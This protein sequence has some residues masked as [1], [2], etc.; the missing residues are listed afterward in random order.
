MGFAVK[1]GWAAAVLLAGP[2]AAP[3]VLDSRRI[4]LS[5]PAIPES[6]QPYH[7]GTGTAREEGPALSRLLETV[8][9]FGGHSVA[10]LIR[11]HHDAQH[12]IVGG[13]VVV[14][15]LIDPATIAN[16]HIRIHAR[17][18][19]LFRRVVEDALAAAGIR[20]VVWRERDLYGIATA[21]LRKWEK[22][23]RA[24]V[25]TL[26]NAVEGAWRSEQKGATV[27]AWVVLSAAA[28]PSS[29]AR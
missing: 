28:I 13:G 24:A 14:G 23:V 20:C 7:A 8:R 25:K 10:E 26:G 3:R 5:D 27:A 19:Q 4:E 1:S 16:A 11:Q 6:R 18:G 22:D 29:S 21:E 9:R 12:Y 15:S 17:E 2:V